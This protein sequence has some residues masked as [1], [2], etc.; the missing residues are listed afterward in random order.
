[1][2]STVLG[3][4]HAGAGIDSPCL[5]NVKLHDPAAS[6]VTFAH[7]VTSSS[8]PVAIDNPGVLA[9]NWASSNLKISSAMSMSEETTSNIGQLSFHP[10][11]T[12]YVLVSFDADGAMYIPSTMDDTVSPPKVLDGNAKLK[13]ESCKCNC[14]SD[15]SET[16]SDTVQGIRA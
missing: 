3:A 7:N 4:C 5:T 11:Q 14:V 12:P 15:W 8:N 16:L 2:P 9:Y 13:V 10:G 6:R 1:M